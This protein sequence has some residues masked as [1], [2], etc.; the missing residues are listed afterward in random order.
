MGGRRK[1]H[2]WSITIVYY[3]AEARSLTGNFKPVTSESGI[4]LNLVV[5]KTKEKY[6]EDFQQI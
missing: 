1:S 6:F 4:C 2:G 5:K 3:K